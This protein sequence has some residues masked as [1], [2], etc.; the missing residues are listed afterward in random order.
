M[1]TGQSARYLGLVLLAGL[2]L[3]NFVSPCQL[4]PRESLTFVLSSG[5][6]KLHH[7]HSVHLKP[8]PSKNIEASLNMNPF[9]R[10]STLNSLISDNLK[11]C[12]PNQ[13]DWPNC[14]FAW[15]DTYKL[16]L[17]SSTSLWKPFR[18]TWM[19]RGSLSFV[20]CL[21]SLCSVTIA[22]PS[23]LVA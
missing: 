4:T 14:S 13:Q 23:S 7:I 11:Q 10:N 3:S 15:R 12:R 21:P 17:S 16:T 19:S 2:F 6:E 20:R 5:Q 1:S 22:Q 8:G 18:F 9:Q